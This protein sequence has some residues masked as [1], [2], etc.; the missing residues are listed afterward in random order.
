M[1]RH[2]FKYDILTSLRVREIIIWLIIYPIALGT[3]FKVAFGNIYD[4]DI[5]FTTVKTAVVVN[6]QEGGKAFRQVA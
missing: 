4:N 2:N 1:F 5:K 6:S 3:F